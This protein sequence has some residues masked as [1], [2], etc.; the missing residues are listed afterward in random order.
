MAKEQHCCHLPRFVYLSYLLIKAS[1]T[2]ECRRCFVWTS[3]FVCI[4]LCG[5]VSKTKSFFGFL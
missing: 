5:L 3:I 4:S 1:F 2:G